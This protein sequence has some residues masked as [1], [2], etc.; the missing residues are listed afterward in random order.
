[1]EQLFKRIGQEINIEQLSK[2]ICV[3][4]QLGQYSKY[5][6]I[7]VGIDDLSY[8]LYTSKEKYLV[9]IMNKEKT[10]EDINKFIQKNMIINQNHIKCPKIIPHKKETIFT[11]YINDVQINLIVMECIDGKDLYS[12]KQLISKEDIE[13][14]VDIVVPLHKIDS[15]I[16]IDDYDE[17]CFMNI[18]Y[19]Y[20]KTKKYL[21]QNIRIQIEETIKEFD[22]IELEK[23]PKCFIHGDLISTNIMKDISNDLW[24]IDFY[25]SGNGIRILDIVKILN[26]VIYNYQYE[27]ETNELEEH[28]LHR[29]A[30]EMP[31]TEYELKVLP[32]LRKA[33]ALVGIMLETYDALKGRNNAENEYWLENDTRLIKKLEKDKLQKMKK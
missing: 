18:K 23:L 2:E 26:S 28:F 4:Y 17:Y 13:K 33:D 9:K 8:Y 29:Y 27:N 3:S 1:M 10:R 15:K 25:E 16:E 7:F 14:L 32:I 21:P 5:E 24:L 31:L 6:L 22:K 12:I 11:Y 30:E 19:D 20:K